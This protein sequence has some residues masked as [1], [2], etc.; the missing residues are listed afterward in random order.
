MVTIPTCHL[1]RPFSKVFVTQL[2][3]RVARILVCFV[4]RLGFR[5][6]IGLGL[7]GALMVTMEY[8]KGG[9]PEMGVWLPYEEVFSWVVAMVW[10][11]WGR[12]GEQMAYLVTLTS[13]TFTGGNTYIFSLSTH[14]FQNLEHIYPRAVF[15]NDIRDPSGPKILQTEYISMQHSCP[16][17]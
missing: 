8:A 6:M 9:S 17:L 4:D 7:G 15:A 16:L 13:N 12:Y 11:C 10:R 5:R 3:G 14:T 2:L 1:S